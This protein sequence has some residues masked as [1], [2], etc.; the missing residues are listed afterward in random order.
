MVPAE[1]SFVLAS[2]VDVRP[3]DGLELFTNATATSESRKWP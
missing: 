1:R 3:L 2:D